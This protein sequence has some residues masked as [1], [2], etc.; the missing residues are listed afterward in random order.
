MSEKT[1]L[2]DSMVKSCVD[3]WYTGSLNLRSSQKTLQNGR[4]CHFI[5]SQKSSFPLQLLGRENVRKWCLNGDAGNLYY[6]M[7]KHWF[8]E[9]AL[10]YLKWEIV[11]NMSCVIQLIY[12]PIDC[13]AYNQQSV[14]DQVP[15]ITQVL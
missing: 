10:G 14:F 1:L 15:P 4:A 9:G 12:V 6:L 2:S 7:Q 13:L 3:N 5:L 8:L 11:S